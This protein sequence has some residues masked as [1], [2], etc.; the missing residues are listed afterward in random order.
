MRSPVAHWHTGYGW[1][2]TPTRLSEL[3]HVSVDIDCLLGTH[4]VHEHGNGP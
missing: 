2:A 3:T 4:A 1:Y